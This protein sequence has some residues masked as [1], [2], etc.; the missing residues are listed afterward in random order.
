MGD[1]DQTIYAWRLADV[2]RM[3]NFT[4]TYPAARRVVLATNYRCPPVVVRCARR[5][6]EANRERIPKPIV[7]GTIDGDPPQISAVDTAQDQLAPLVDLATR[8]GSR[9]ERLCF[10]ART[11]AELEPIRLAL[12][13]AGV[14]HACSLP[15]PLDARPVTALIAA[16]SRQSPGDPPFESLR[17]LRR[18]HGWDRSTHDEALA[19]EELNAL[20]VLLGWAAAE[21]T[22]ESFLGRVDDA[23]RRMA[24]VSDA[25]A[26]VELVTVHGAKG[27]EWETVVVLGYEEERFPNRRALVDAAEPERALEEERRLAYVAVTRA[28][29]RLMLAFDPARPS[30]FL[31][32]M[33]LTAQPRVR[34]R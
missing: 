28:R 20:D 18:A 14:A 6:I 17:R 12:L 8:A 32:E 4:H 21:A 15:W 2:R 25:E 24:A 9:S 27:R 26:P 16:L 3:L 7:P 13:Q 30:R 34:R 23:R 10:L 33:G 29:R 31:A 19:E 22:V 11:R 1:D 5:L